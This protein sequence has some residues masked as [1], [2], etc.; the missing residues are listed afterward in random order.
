MFASH[1]MKFFMHKRILTLVIVPMLMIL[2]GCG[3]GDMSSAGTVMEQSEPSLESS[4][5]PSYD[6]QS[7]ISLQEYEIIKYYDTRQA[8]A[9]LS[10]AEF[11]GIERYWYEDGYGLAM[12]EIRGNRIDKKEPDGTKSFFYE[13]PDPIDL[14]Y[15][16]N[17]DVLYFLS[18]GTVYRLFVPDRT[19]EQI[20]CNSEISGFFPVTNFS[21][22]YTKE[23]PQ[24]AQKDP[25]HDRMDPPL[26]FIYNAH[27]KEDYEIY[28]EDYGLDSFG[29]STRVD[30]RLFYVIDE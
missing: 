23:N 6:P 13:H 17:Q 20:Y 28:P 29:G 1:K 19:V 21:I 2:T 14:I 3:T 18:G 9:C 8:N 5:Y 24:N 15:W 7:G 4:A 22:L 30:S 12:L 11:F 10:Y 27:T 26:S 25:E 16:D